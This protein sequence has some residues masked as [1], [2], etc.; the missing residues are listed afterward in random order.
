MPPPDHPSPD[1]KKH[2]HE[3]QIGDLVVS[4]VDRMN[5]GEKVD[6][7]RILEDHPTLGNQILEELSIFCDFS[8]GCADAAPASGE[9]LPPFRTLGDY[10]LRRQIGRGGMG[11]IFDAWEKSMDRRVALKV[12]PAAVHENKKAFTRFLREAKAAGQLSH[13]NVVSVYSRGVD[14][15][16]AYYAMEYVEGETLDATLRRIA[17]PCRNEDSGFSFA[18][19]Q[20]LSQ[21]LALSGSSIGRVEDPSKSGSGLG[22]NGAVENR[23]LRFACYSRIAEAFADVA[24]GL[25]HAHTLG[26]IHRDL[27]PSNLMLSRSGRLRILDFGLAWIQGQEHL[28]L[29]DESVG[30]PLYMSPEQAEPGPH[31]VGPATDVYSLGV[32][33]YEVLGGRPPLRGKN[34]QQTLSLIT[35]RDPLPL[36]KLNPS[37]PHDLET[38]VHK[39]L[40][41]SPRD[42]YGT[43]EALAQDLR[44]FAFGYPIE[45]RHYSDWKRL[46]HRSW[47]NRGRIAAAATI[48]ILLIGTTLLGL[49]H[50][51]HVRLLRAAEY[52]RRITDIVMEGQ[53]GLFL[54]RLRPP[55]TG[56]GRYEQ[57]VFISSGT[58]ISDPLDFHAAVVNTALD[59]VRRSLEQLEEVSRLQKDRPDA[60]F[61][62]ARILVL[63]GRDREAMAK[64]VEI[65]QRHPCFV[66]A[67][68]LQAALLAKH[69]EAELSSRVLDKAQQNAEDEWA[70]AWFEAHLAVMQGE[71]E[72]ADAAFGRLIDLRRTGDRPYLGSSIDMILG[73]GSARLELGETTRAIENFAMAQG[74]WQGH[75]EPLLLLGKAYLLEGKDAHAERKFHDLLGRDDVDRDVIRSRIAHI[76]FSLDRNE[77]ALEWASDIEDE[78]LREQCRAPVLIKMGNHPAAL[79][80]AETALAHDPDDELS[81]LW[82][83]LALLAGSQTET[84]DLGEAKQV[85]RRARELDPTNPMA[86]VWLGDALARAGDLDEALQAYSAAARLDPSNAWAHISEGVT[87]ERLGCLDRAFDEYLAALEINPA[88]TAVYQHLDGLLVRPATGSRVGL[89]A[90]LDRFGIV[91]ERVV[92]A[93]ARHPFLPDLLRIYALSLAGS[94]RP[95]LIEKSL[96]YAS[97]AVEATHHAVP[98]MLSAL[99]AAQYANGRT[100]QAIQTL[101]R[102]IQLPHASRKDLQTLQDYRALL[103][104]RLVSCSSVDTILQAEDTETVIAEGDMW[105]LFKGRSDPSPGAVHWSDP[106]FDDSSWAPMPSGFGYGDSDDRTVLDDMMGQYT[107]IYIRKDFGVSDANRGCSCRLRV[108][109]DDGCVAYLNGVEVLRSGVR[110]APERVSHLATA[111]AVVSLEPPDPVEVLLDLQ[112]IRP[113]RNV[114]ALQGLNQS[115]SSSDLSLIPVLETLRPP[116]PERDARILTAFRESDDGSHPVCA[117]YFEG[118]IRQRAGQMEAAAECFRKALAARD[119]PPPEPIVRLAECLV[120]SRQPEEAETMLVSSL[121]RH[122]AGELTL[123]NHWYTLSVLVLDRSPTQLLAKMAEIHRVQ[124]GRDPIWPD[125][126]GYAGDLRWILERLQRREPIRINCGGLDYTDGAGNR[127]SRDRFFLGGCRFGEQEWSPYPFSGVIVYHGE[128]E[129]TDDDPLYQS[130]RW[131]PPS[132]LAPA[133]YRIPLVPGEYRVTLHFAEIHFEQPGHRAFDILIEGEKLRRWYEPPAETRRADSWSHTTAVLDG[134]LDIEFVKQIEHPKISAIEIEPLSE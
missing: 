61:Q 63:R 94:D 32:T 105:R 49:N 62:Q 93:D 64:T 34:I 83:G 66:P 104:P 58:A 109:I 54:T 14:Q 40:R 98:R 126:S 3:R 130:E 110:P 124:P 19:I 37:V 41:K 113:G 1:E 33:L 2:D 134:F 132:G 127:W 22:L 69:G 92:R 26:I 114:L 74:R 82:K 9:P 96:R 76:F 97:M 21:V 71:W 11:V 121:G 125:I 29:S 15:D 68:L 6:A 52:E 46:L 48:L 95:E 51:E 106:G 86:H 123:W 7:D 59:P 39:C 79:E 27:K 90:K 53:T 50:W 8:S 65:L 108:V 36:S 56:D 87:L 128:I 70:G 44:R 77:T 131:F 31:E 118:R 111:T 101:E 23:D 91:L 28:T 25:H 18:E 120:A 42:R 103:S 102:A 38:I 60:W 10:I 84:E 5:S 72:K 89:K 88:L 80:A 30:T 116:D 57:G 35:S 16:T 73:Q 117:A 12:L 112:H 43:A 67:L 81:L 17:G 13:P 115:I 75:V 129:G 133:G 107:T 24:D 78:S 45:A 122:A 100:D 47:R 119:P 85:L 55:K 4:Y 99:A 20:S